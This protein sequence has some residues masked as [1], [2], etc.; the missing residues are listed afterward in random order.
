[1]GLAAIMVEQ[2][3]R[4]TVHLR[5]DDAL[6]AVD[7]EGAVLRHERHVAH[8]DVLL[9][10]IEHRTGLGIGIHLEHDQAERHA[11]RRGESDAALAA[12]FDVILRLFELVVDEI[13]FGGAGE[14]ADR[15]HAAQRL[16][17]PRH[18]ADRWIG[19]Q[20]LLVALSL[21]LD[22]VR[23]L[24][25]FVDVA[26]HL[27][28]ALLRTGDHVGWDGLAGHVGSV[29]AVKFRRG[30][31]SQHPRQPDAT[32]KEPRKKVRSRAVGATL[33]HFF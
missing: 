13:Q 28:D 32:R 27:A 25:D 3:A 7:E 4:R 17:Q 14:V 12:L 31:A 21:D 5:D 6:S 19:A 20:E 18:I 1:M 2:H 29:L 8:V 22:Q 16:L 15:E 23:H 24:H 11:H 26:E 33:L 9:L 10:D 30:N